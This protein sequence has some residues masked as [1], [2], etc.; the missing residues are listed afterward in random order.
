M[1]GIAL[2][3]KPYLFEDLRKA[4]Q[5]ILGL[6]DENASSGQILPFSIG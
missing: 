5:D 2:L 4:I 3:Q 1:D 6:V